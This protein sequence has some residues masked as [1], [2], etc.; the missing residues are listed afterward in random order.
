L[1]DAAQRSMLLEGV[2]RQRGNQ[3]R[4]HLAKAAPHVLNYAA[5][6]AI[7]GR[8]LDTPVN[9]GFVRIMRTRPE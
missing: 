7:D 5:G 4:E 2:V 8:T 3:Y 9:C 1:I 6:L